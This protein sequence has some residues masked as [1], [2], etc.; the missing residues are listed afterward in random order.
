MSLKPSVELFS[1]NL[2]QLSI[3]CLPWDVLC[4]KGTNSLE[5]KDT[6]SILNL[7]MFTW[8]YNTISGSIENSPCTII[9]INIQIQYL[10]KVNRSMLKRI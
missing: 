5:R 7:L 6:K 10:L 3:V 1:L 9:R 2:I 4:Y 8:V